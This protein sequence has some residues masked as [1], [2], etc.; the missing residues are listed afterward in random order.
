[1]VPFFFTGLDINKYTNSQKTLLQVVT[2]NVATNSTRGREHHSWQGFLK[3][4]I[5]I[6]VETLD[7]E[8]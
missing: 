5:C 3:V 8:W 7:K 4:G 2:N 6:D 1:M